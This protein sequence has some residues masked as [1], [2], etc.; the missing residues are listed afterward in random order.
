MNIFVKKLNKM[1][2]ILVAIF[3]LLAVNSCFAQNDKQEAI[4]LEKQILKFSKL[5]GDPIVNINSLYKL[6]AL[7]GDNSIYKDSLAY[8]YFSSGKYAPCYMV[9]TDVLNRQPNNKN[10]LEM[11]AISLEALGAIGKGIESYSKLFALSNNNF[12]GYSLAKL[13]YSTKEFEEAYTTIQKVE[14]LNDSGN[15]KVT[16]GINKTHSQQIELIAAI[17]YL[18][19]IIAIELEKDDIAKISFQKAIT[20]QPEFVLAKE[21]LEALNEKNNK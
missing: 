9:A 15:Y 6:I 4:A 1:K 17:Q 20:I 14:K 13:Q 18:K 12:H 11:Q 2:S 8:V 5:N 21:K 7:E 16:Y 10:M 19:G 3:S